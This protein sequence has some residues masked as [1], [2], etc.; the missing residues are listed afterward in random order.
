M[1]EAVAPPD[2][3]ARDRI[4]TIS[5][6]RCS[7]RPA[8]GRARPTALVD[9]VLALVTSGQAELRAIAAITFTEKAAAEL[10]D[11]IRQRARDGPRRVTPTA[12]RRPLPTRPRAARRGRHRHPALLRPAHPLRAP[13]RSGS[14]A[15]GRGPRRGQLRGRLRA[16]LVDLPRRAA[17]RPGLERTILLLLGLPG[18]ASTPC[19]R[20]PRPSTTTGTWSTSVCRD[21]ARAAR[22]PDL[23]GRK[24]RSTI[25][26]SSAPSRAATRPTSSAPARRDRRP[27]GRAAADDRRARPAR[28]PRARRTAKLA[29]LQAR[30]QGASQGSFDCDLDE[31]RVGRANGRRA[32]RAVR[33]TGWPTPAPSA[34][35]APSAA[36]P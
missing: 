25:W 16:A 23:F 26:S 10:R 17:R 20:W 8:P 32:S 2:Q 33:R 31:L 4:P 28:G 27:R 19:G 7:S 18:S 13:G 3:P 6:P 12:D 24:H 35:A 1:P 15:A 22:R 11:R 14:A 5:T 34:S 21:R 29:Q 9:R 36:S 30:E